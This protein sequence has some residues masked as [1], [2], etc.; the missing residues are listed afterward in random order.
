MKMKSTVIDFGLKKKKKEK[1]RLAQWYIFFYYL[2][3]AISPFALLLQGIYI[4]IF[5]K[6]CCACV[7]TF[8]VLYVSI[9][10]Q[11]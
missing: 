10:S 11:S 8:V 9:Y 7:H 3:P 4:C 6:V 5:L 2:Y 1:E